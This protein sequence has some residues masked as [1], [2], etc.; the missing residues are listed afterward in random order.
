MT[1]LSQYN[2]FYNKSTTTAEQWHVKSGKVALT[3]SGLVTGNAYTP[4]MMVFDGSSD[5]S[6]TVTPSV[7]AF[8]AIV[9]FAVNDYSSGEP[10]IAA[11]GW[12]QYMTKP[13]GLCLENW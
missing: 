9:R 4:G 3:Q 2:K 8:T 1:A 7:N 10:Y 6:R 13:I 11:C 5:Y 12:R